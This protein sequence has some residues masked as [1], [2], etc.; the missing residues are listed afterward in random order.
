MNITK[1]EEGAFYSALILINTENK[2]ACANVKL[3]REREREE[4]IN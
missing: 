3:E 2:H 1:S 4:Y